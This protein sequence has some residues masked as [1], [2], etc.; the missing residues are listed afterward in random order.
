LENR[1]RN[2][3]LPLVSLKDIKEFLHEEY[4]IIFYYDT[5]R[6]CMIPF[7]GKFRLLNT[8]SNPTS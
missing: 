7:P 6:G 8:K 4:G 3:Y 2:E 1:V 5:R